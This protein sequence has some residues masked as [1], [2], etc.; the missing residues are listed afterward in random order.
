[1]LGQRASGA[2]V[3]SMHELGRSAARPE[4]LYPRTRRG[5]RYPARA[6]TVA[7]VGRGE[8]AFIER[9]QRRIGAGGPDGEIFVGDDAAVVRPPG[10]RMLFATDL[11]VEGVHFDLSI[12]SVADAGWKAVVANAS[13][14][15]AMGGIPLFAVSAVSAPPGTDLD[16][17]LDGI[18]EAAGTCGLQLVGGD[19]SGGEHLVIAVAIVGSCGPGGPVLRSGAQPGDEIWV[20]A[21]L[22]SSAAALRSLRAGGGEHED[23]VGAYRR[24]LARLREGAAAARAGVTAMIDISDGLSSD[25][26][27]IADASGVGVRLE[28]VP[29]APGADEADALG[30][31]ED[32]E[33]LFTAPPG[34][35]LELAFAEDG[36]AAPIRIGRCTGEQGELLLRGVTMPRSG[37]EHDFGSGR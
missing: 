12:G 30:G 23:G 19:L 9:L 1:M 31:G 17:V 5:K 27:H 18:L 35:G 11:V 33:L 21:P 10:E 34:C 20:T 26:G 24:P 15:A 2:Q 7:A 6:V 3:G 4:R 16:Q 14:V 29:V 22:G 8:F 25:A 37:F 13:D 28:D 32:Y 36:L